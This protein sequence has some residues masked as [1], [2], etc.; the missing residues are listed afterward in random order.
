MSDISLFC[1]WAHAH[2]IWLDQ[3]GPEHQPFSTTQF[4]SQERRIKTWISANYIKHNWDCVTPY[5]VTSAQSISHHL[6][7]AIRYTNIKWSKQIEASIKHRIKLA[8]WSNPNKEMSS[9]K[10][11][12]YFLFFS[13][14]LKKK[15]S[16]NDAIKQAQLLYYLVDWI[17]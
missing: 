13:F 4:P 16:G 8:N 5:R 7:K 9:W 11:N 14:F 10:D 2:P 17:V 3:P 6:T 12:Q 1:V 15:K